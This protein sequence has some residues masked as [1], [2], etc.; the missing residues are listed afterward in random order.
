MKRFVLILFF[1]LG[2]SGISFSQKTLHLDV[3]Y[4]LFKANDTENFLELHYALYPQEWHYITTPAAD[5]VGTILMHLDVMEGKKIIYQKNWRVVNSI[6]KNGKDLSLK[7]EIDLLRLSLPPNRYSVNLLAVDLNDTTRKQSRHFT[8]HVPKFSGKKIASSSLELCRS[9]RK[10]GENSVPLFVKNN[11]EVVPNP[12]L[13][14]GK[15][16]PT[17]YFYVELYN[18]LKGVPQSKYQ[19][20]Y[21]VT[22]YS[23][24]VVDS[25]RP[26]KME[27]TKVYDSSV[28]VGQMNVSNLPSGSYWLFFT[29][30]DTNNK[31]LLIV[32]KRFFTFN[33]DVDKRVQKN[34]KKNI[35]L[36]PTV[37]DEM[38]EARVNEE[39]NYIQYLATKNEKKMI[40]RLN[41]VE[42][43]RQFLKEFWARRDPSPAT[44]FNEKR[45]EFLRRVQYANKKFSVLGLKGWKTDF[46]RVYI[47]YGPP[48]DIERSPNTDKGRAY[49]VWRYE[50]LQGGVIFVFIDMTGYHRY[51]LVHSTYRDEIQNY[52]WPD[53]LELNPQHPNY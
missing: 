13:L 27:K 30:S 14:Y 8:I 38:P 40:K 28:E 10:S 31:S 33:P 50:N 20:D 1:L 39:L 44:P 5:T 3:D 9:I 32:K 49:Q 46:G 48:D 11:L 53:L 37:F 36:G 47:V 4:D 23:G 26:R 7:E 17:L 35:Q 42:T 2:I 41:S 21:F 52:D 15:G 25:I 51:Q 12:S 45:A 22:D 24:N 29:I 16:N 6:K 18:L 19:V 34:R 43:K